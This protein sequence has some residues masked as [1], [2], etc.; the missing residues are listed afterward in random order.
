MIRCFI[1]LLV[2]LHA[3]CAVDLTPL[4]QITVQEGGRKKPFLVFGEESI[5]ETLA[6]VGGEGN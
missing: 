5:L 1:A 3:A 4:E 6:E 2:A